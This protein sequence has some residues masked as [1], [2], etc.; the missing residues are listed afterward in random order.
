MRRSRAYYPYRG[1]RTI[2][3]KKH[4]L[5]AAGFLLLI[6]GAIGLF[7]PILPTTPFILVASACF[8]GNPRIRSWLLKNRFFQEH[9]TNYQ[10]R[11]GLKK[12]TIALS[13]SFLWVTLSASALVVGKL[14]LALLLGSI[15][16]AVTIHILCVSRPKKIPRGDLKQKP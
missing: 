7:V 6:I 2:K 12:S 8:T 11:T 13:L 4:L 16:A 5:S 9:L 10:Q 3:I 14:W 15:G 1:V